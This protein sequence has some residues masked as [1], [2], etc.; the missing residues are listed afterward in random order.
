MIA[1]E[2]LQNAIKMMLALD[3]EGRAQ[4]LNGFLSG[5]DKHMGVQ[6]SRVETDRIE[7]YCDITEKHLQVFGLV[8]GGVY[9]SLSETFCSTGGAVSVM[10]TGR[11][12][13]GRSNSTKFLKAARASQRLQISATS[14]EPVS[15][16]I[17]L[18]KCQIHDGEGLVF[19]VSEVQLNVLDSNHVVGGE[20]LEFKT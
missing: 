2:E 6:F 9:A 13:V 3:P 14:S 12:V 5:H 18:W 4:A 1:P 11:N 8:H 16:K 10:S 17:L 7:G 15:D 20:A 19:A